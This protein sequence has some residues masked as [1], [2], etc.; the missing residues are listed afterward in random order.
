MFRRVEYDIAE[1]QARFKTVP[2]LPENNWR[3][4][5]KGE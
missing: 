4:L 5:A 3:R 1:V 2:Q